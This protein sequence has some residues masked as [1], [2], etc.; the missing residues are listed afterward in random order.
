MKVI[1]PVRGCHC[2]EVL[3]VEKGT[4]DKEPVVSMDHVSIRKENTILVYIPALAGRN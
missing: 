3:L 1:W 2:L 4:D